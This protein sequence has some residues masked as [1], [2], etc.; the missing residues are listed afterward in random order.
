MI[1]LIMLVAEGK[2]YLH[3]LDNGFNGSTDPKLMHRWCVANNAAL[4]ALQAHVVKLQE[5][6]LARA[7]GGVPFHVIDLHFWHYTLEGV[8][9]VDES[10]LSDDEPDPAY[11]QYD[12]C[13]IHQAY[14]YCE[15]VPRP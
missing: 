5:S 9:V 1:Y 12:W 7:V 6:D 11:V 2:K 14:H 4:I 15:Y 13:A 3:Y 10:V 8:P